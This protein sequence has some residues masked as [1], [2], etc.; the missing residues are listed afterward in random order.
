MNFRASLESALQLML[1]Y[2]AIDVL[3]TDLNAAGSSVVELRAATNQIGR[4]QKLEF[5]IRTGT[6]YTNPMNP[7]ELEVNLQLTTPK[8]TTLSVP[9]FWCQ[10]YERRRLS[11]AQAGRDWLYP[12]GSPGWQARWAPMEPGTYRATAVVKDRNGTSASKEVRFKCWPATNPGFVRVSRS[13]PRFLQFDNAQPFF[14]IGQNL[15]FIGDEQ[16]VGLANLEGIF[17][18]LAGNGGNYLRI[19]TCCGDWA[20]AIEARKSAWG[21]SWD[22]RPS[23]SAVPDNP[24]GKLKCLTLASEHP[25]LQAEP[26]HRL[27]L[28]P[29]TRYTLS[30]RLR[31]EGGATVSIHFNQVQAGVSEGGAAEG[32]RNFRV[33]V[34]TAPDEFWLA[35]LSFRLEGSGRAWLDGLSL[36]EAGGGPELLWEA[37]VNR[38]ERGYYNPLDCFVLDEIVAAA[39]RHGIYLQLCFIT[40][41]VYMAALKDSGNPAYDQAIADARKL[42]RY[43]IARWGYSTAVAAWEYWNEMDPGLPTDR[44]YTALG[45]Y[46]EQADP[47][48]HLRTTSTWGP[49]AKDCRHPKLDIADVHFYLRPADKGRLE[50]EVDAVLERTRWLRQQAPNKPAH[51]GEFG[52]A[53]DKWRITEPMQRNP[54]IAD[55]HNA[56]WASALSGASGTAMFWWW[57][58]LDQRDGY[59]EYRP[60]SRFVA[61]V[62][63]NSGKVASLA[64]SCSNGGVR[65]IGLRAGNRAWLW[66]FNRS[67]AWGRMVLDNQSPQPISRAQVELG[68]FEPGTFRVEWWNTRTGS[69]LRKDSRRVEAGRLRLTAPDFVGDVACKIAQ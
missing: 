18:K 24:T 52:L 11:G 33:E 20:M 25:V 47:Y 61:D 2:A 14:P 36:R 22:W 50:D 6:G 54:E 45:E 5:E 15:A 31:T 67:A 34:Q 41:D 8:R 10:P 16:Y 30:G 9:A 69:V 35:E 51:L 12:V 38:P 7:D 42:A 44:F 49:S 3:T 66:L 48:H 27:A 39:E 60:L 64:A 13:D 46:F 21:R 57:E 58:R 4:Y 62:P 55:V 29:G 37:D 56:L 28:R 63:W 1:G 68:S 43:F 65:P 17:G 59:V 53:D 23:I 32:W 40:R 26:S 19:W